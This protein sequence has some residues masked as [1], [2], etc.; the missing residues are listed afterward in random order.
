MLTIPS[1]L[2]ILT[3]SVTEWD[4]ASS[5]HNFAEVNTLKHS[6]TE[7]GLSRR[8]YKTLSSSKKIDDLVKEKDDVNQLISLIGR[9]QQIL[10][11]DYEKSK[12]LR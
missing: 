9:L 4:S 10:I 8:V 11:F 2:K 6:L 5:L 1:L 12:K 3:E 7:S